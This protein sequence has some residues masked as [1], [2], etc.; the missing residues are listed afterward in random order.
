MHTWYLKELFLQFWQI[1]M[2]P[3]DADLKLIEKSNLI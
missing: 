2:L 3:H 1:K